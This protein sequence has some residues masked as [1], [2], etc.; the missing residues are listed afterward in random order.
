MRAQH[1]KGVVF[2]LHVLEN[3]NAPNIRGLELL[4]KYSQSDEL[5][6]FMLSL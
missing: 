3:I 6:D 2:D 4:G 5:R 1:Q